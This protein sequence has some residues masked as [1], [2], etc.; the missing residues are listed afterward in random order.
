MLGPGSASHVR[1]P[2]TP[3][4]ETRPADDREAA[5]S[6]ATRPVESRIARVAPLPMP[7]SAA[8][9]RHARRN[10]LRRRGKQTEGRRQAKTYQASIRKMASGVRTR[11]PSPRIIGGPLGQARAP[12]SSHGH[13]RCDI[14]AVFQSRTTQ[15][16]PARGLALR[17]FPPACDQPPVK[18]F[19]NGIWPA[20]KHV[21]RAEVI[22]ASSLAGT[23]RIAVRREGSGQSSR[24]DDA[25]LQDRDE[26]R[27]I[28]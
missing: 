14:F 10:S 28:S 20:M 6:T 16:A 22:N 18:V 21:R 13:E 9:R 25:R 26:L 2:A 3:A 5:L 1:L 11:K 23:E 12:K 8:R 27:S 17:L 24:F 7:S 4:V 19:L 15:R